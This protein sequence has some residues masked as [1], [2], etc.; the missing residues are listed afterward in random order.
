MNLLK[1]LKVLLTLVLLIPASTVLAGQTVEISDTAVPPSVTGDISDW[2]IPPSIILDKKEQVVSGQYEW[3]GPDYASAKIYLTYDM[4]N[5]YIAADITSKTP[6]YNAQEAGNVYNGDAIELFIGTDLTD[7]KRTALVPTDLQIIISP[8]KNG[9]NP[10]VYCTTDKTAVPG[11]KVAT[12]LTKNGYALFAQIPMS[13]LYKINVGPGKS[14]GFDVDLDDVGSASK[15]RALQLSWTQQDKS[16]QDPSQWGTLTFKGNTVFVNTA[17]KVNVPGVVLVDTDPKAGAKGASKEG[18]LIWGFN[19]DLG[20]FTG[21]VGPEK[22]IFSEGTGA[23]AVSTTGSSGWNQNLA[24]CKTVPVPEKW[25]SFKTITMDAY[26]PPK[27]LAKAGF[28]ELYLI[29]QSP[30]NSW[31]EIKM[32]AQEG[33]NHFKTD[34]DSTQFKGGLQ[35]V[36]MV[37][38]SGGPINGSVIVDNIRGIEKGATCVM[39]GVITDDAAKPVEGASVAVGKNLVKSGADGAFSV[40]VPADEYSGEVFAPGFAQHKENLKVK[41]GQDNVWNVSLKPVVASTE[42]ATINV[43]MAPANKGYTINPHYFYGNNIATWY[44]TKSLTDPVALKE[45]GD[46]SKYIRIPGGAFGNVWDW[47]TGSI[48]RNDGVSVQWTPDVKWADLVTYLK[49]TN[50]EPLMIANIMTED[51]QSCLD[52]IADAKAQ[53][54]TVNYVELGNE[55]DYAAEL[56]YKGET[57]Y[58]TVIDNYCKA[59]LEFAK[60]IKAKYPDIKLMGPCPAQVEER[61]R[62]E[63]E[64][65]LAAETSPWW[66]EKFLEECGPYVDVVS[67]HSYPYFNNDSDVTLLSKLNHWAEWVPKIREAIKKNIPDR[68]D[69]IEIAVTEW[70]SGDETPTTAKLINGVFCADYL[71]Q[72]AVWGVNQTNIWDMMTQKPGQG[73][74]HGLIDPTGDPDHPYAVRSTYWIMDLMENHF[75][76]ELYQAKADQADLD[77]YASKGNGKKY[78][79]VVNKN[80]KYAYTTKVNLGVVKAKKGKVKY[81]IY[82]LG[83]NEYQ[84]SENLYKAMINSGPTH[85]T[86]TGTKSGFTATFPPYSVTCVE[87]P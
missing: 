19:G 59:Y 71:A 32:T 15:V 69:K 86:A 43:L 31:Y 79:M 36:Y 24:I 78:L 85:L 45:A 61:E 41:A 55:P 6:M 67:V 33:W 84:W 3:T 18:D 20:G 52:W 23:M 40:E 11:A 65:W 82:Q 63:G 60:A 58:W 46:I 68:A 8:G 5:L 64:P 1:K 66:V 87:M 16:W 26:Y 29:T 74:G 80:P 37:F 42:S 48:F 13:F 28:G 21:S 10:V 56:A 57:H 2:K 72:M 47:K 17:P 76:T 4:N 81:N 49:T 50:S 39:K 7:P 30:A 9:A 27:S 35:K 77:A 22:N 34:V 12:K 51:V 75:G 83:P 14:I 25:E 44:T 38:N 54:L 62:K 70:N 73:G 53:G